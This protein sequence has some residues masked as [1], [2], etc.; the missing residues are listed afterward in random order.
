VGPATVMV[1]VPRNTGKHIVRVTTVRPGMTGD[2]LVVVR[3]LDGS[4]KY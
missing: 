3:R 1:F 4:P 2:Y